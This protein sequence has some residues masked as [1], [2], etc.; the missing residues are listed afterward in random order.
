MTIAILVFSPF[1]PIVRVI[2]IERAIKTRSKELVPEM[3]QRRV[4]VITL[5]E[6]KD[7]QYL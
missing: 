1:L 7:N 2:T 6:A 3:K 4:R 5:Q